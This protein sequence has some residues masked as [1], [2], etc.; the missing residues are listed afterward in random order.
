MTTAKKCQKK[1]WDTRVMTRLTTGTTCNHNFGLNYGCED[2]LYALCFLPS[3]G[4][5]VHT[6]CPLIENAPFSVTKKET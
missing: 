2:Y 4:T 6:E 1:N 5:Q 3:N